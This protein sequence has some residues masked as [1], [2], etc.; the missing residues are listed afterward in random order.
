MNARFKFAFHVILSLAIFSSGLAALVYEVVFM[1][2]LT[3]VFGTTV[4]S[5]SCVLA[6]F[7]AG[8][9]L[10]SW[11]LGKYVGR[12]KNPLYGYGLIE[13]GIGGFAYLVSI[14]IPKIELL[15]PFLF[16]FGAGVDQSPLFFTVIQFIFCFLLLLPP[17]VLMGA[18]FPLVTHF[19]VSDERELGRKV[20]FFYAINT[21]GGAVGALLSAYFLIPILGISGT[22]KIT[23]GINGA[24]GLII[25]ILSSIA[26]NVVSAPCPPYLAKSE[27][28]PLS[29][30]LKKG[31]MVSFACS[32][33]FA[34]AY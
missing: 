29:P 25:L 21:F 9:S 13:L 17:T 3:L 6:S 23:V 11:L 27:A 5:V 30:L 33:F 31:V 22:V 7:M 19:L 20:G 8:L 32:G 28:S 26:A 15:Y 18:T 34:L 2:K 12:F 14:L 10:G 1:R 4:Y 16:S 24:I